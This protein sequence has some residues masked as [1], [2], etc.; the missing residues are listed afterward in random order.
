MSFLYYNTVVAGLMSQIDSLM[1]SFVQNGYN[2]LAGA[3][4]LPL[5]ALGSLF[6]ILMGYGITYGFIKAP[7]QELYKFIIRLGFIYFFAMNWGNFSF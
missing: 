1:V 4:K 6:I 5:V 7:L 3:L 2:A